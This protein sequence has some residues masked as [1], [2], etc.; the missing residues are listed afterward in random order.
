M[1]TIDF[2]ALASWCRASGYRLNN[3]LPSLP[4]AASHLEFP[5]PSEAQDIP[6][7]LD[8]LVR[9]GSEGDEY[10]I[11]ARDWTIWTDRS[12]E[13]GLRHWDLLV[14]VMGSPA[15]GERSRIVIL[16]DSEWREAIAL[17]VVAALYGWDAHLFFRSAAAL[18]N[19]S[20]DGRVAVALQKGVGDYLQT[21]MASDT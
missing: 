12:Q 5:L 4:L 7:L 1:Q 20:H 14:D 3:W 8:G 15:N 18:V 2:E 9:L 17:L 16:R 11:W 21:W 19:L 10:L 13:I 6:Q